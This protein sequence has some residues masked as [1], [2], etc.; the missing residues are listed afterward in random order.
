MPEHPT[1]S[2]SNGDPKPG[3]PGP[4]GPPA[5]KRSV[6]SRA[7]SLPRWALVTI[8]GALIG[9]LAVGGLTKAWN[10]LSGGN[11]DIGQQVEHVRSK[12]IASGENVGYHQRLQLRPGVE[13]QVFVLQPAR[14]ERRSAE[15]RI[16]DEEKGNLK[17]K[18]HFRPRPTD[19]SHGFG[20]PFQQVVV[21][22]LNGDGTQE[23]VGAYV[24]QG[25]SVN[26]VFVP[27]VAYWN[28]SRDRYEIKPLLATP[29]EPFR[30]PAPVANSSPFDSAILRR[31]VD[32]D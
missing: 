4:N 31:Q 9:T 19:T 13:S 27:V 16:Y 17:L 20:F 29:P 15:I 2:A 32:L 3:S 7:L 24:G 28:D 23:V 11:Q 22:D 25:A 30:L 18:L 8:A 10:L 26:N 14:S 12:A 5:T 1:P 6:V 21:S